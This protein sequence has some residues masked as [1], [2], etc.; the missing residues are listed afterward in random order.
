LQLDLDEG[1]VLPELVP[2]GNLPERC[3]GLQG[4]G[5][6]ISKLPECD[7]KFVFAIR[8]ETDMR[9][10]RFAGVDECSES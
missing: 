8:L 7:I 2:C 10:E 1:A 6:C 9:I 3:A 4:D 5:A